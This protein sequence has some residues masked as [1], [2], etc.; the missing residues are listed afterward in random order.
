[1]LW[2]LHDA[3]CTDPL[4][5]L[6]L[7]VLSDYADDDGRN[8]FPA[9]TTISETVPCSRAT[10]YRHLQLLQQ[11]GLIQAQDDQGATAYLRADRR[12]VVWQLHLPPRGLTVRPR[13]LLTGSHNPPSRG[14][15]RGLTGETQPSNPKDNPRQAARETDDGALIGCADHAP[16]RSP[17]C[18]SCQRQLGKPRAEVKPVDPTVIRRL[19][20][21]PA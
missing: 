14:L 20:E 4:S 18:P 7:L 10:V 11:Q 2:A 16:R 13:P 5:K 21:R 3:P 8:A 1:M 15:T 17:A 12:P 6:V 9:A 19:R